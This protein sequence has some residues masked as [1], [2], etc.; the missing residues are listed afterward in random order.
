[1]G[2]Q[3]SLIS[4]NHHEPVNQMRTDPEITVVLSIHSPLYL[5]D[6]LVEIFLEGHGVSVP[7]PNELFLYIHDSMKW[8]EKKNP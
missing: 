2:A 8:L 7:V 6:F 1:M 3:R 4:L 5:L